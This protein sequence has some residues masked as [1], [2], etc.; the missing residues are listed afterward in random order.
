[1]IEAAKNAQARS[2]RGAAHL[3]AHSLVPSEP[4]L[5]LLLMDVSFH[6]RN[7]LIRTSRARPRAGRTGSRGAR[8]HTRIP[9][10]PRSSLPSA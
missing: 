7:S 6:L 9:F 2:L 5:S 1:V 4:R 10:L 3:L 8:R